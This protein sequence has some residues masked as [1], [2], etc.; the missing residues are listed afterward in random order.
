MTKAAKIRE[1]ARLGNSVVEIAGILGIRY[2]HAYHVLSRSGMLPTKVPG[3]TR[4]RTPRRTKA[5]S[6]KPPLSVEILRSGG[7]VSAG[8]W[9][10][11]LDGRIELERP[12]PKEVATYAFVVD[13][14]AVYVGVATSTLAKRFRSYVRPGPTQRTSSR[15]NAN[16]RELLVQGGIV[17]IY[18]ATPP[19]LEWNGLPI[20]ASAGL[21]L[22]LI[23]RF[24]LEWNSRSAG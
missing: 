2:Q 3:E 18:V 22:G 10:L 14:F 20:H 8:S 24:S 13:G 17:E 1:L 12:L 16:I 23:E 6:Q 19:D 11:S 5:H 4:A 21:E 15:L 9:T 7:F